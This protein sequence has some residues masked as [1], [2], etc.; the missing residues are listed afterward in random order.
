[1]SGPHGTSETN[2]MERARLAASDELVQFLRRPDAYP[3]S[4]PHVECVETHISWVFL[5]DRHAYKLKKPVKHD[6]VDFS[7][8]ELRRAACQRE[9]QLNRR[10]A[11]AVYLGVVPVTRDRRG[12][13]HLGG[14]NGGPSGGPGVGLGTP[15]DWLVHMRRLPADKSL[16]ALLRAG[17]LDAADVEHLAERLVR[18]YR[19]LPPLPVKTEAY[20]QAIQ[21]HVS[22]NFR[23][24][25]RAE[26]QLPKGTVWRPHAAQ[27]RLL[28]LYP[29]LWDARV[30]DGRVIEGHGD[31]RPEHVYFV[32]QPVLIDA[33]EFNAELRQIDVLDELGFLAMECAALDAPW[34]GRQ[35]LDRYMTATGD[36]PAEILLRFYEAYRACVRAKVHALRAAQEKPLDAQSD[37]DRAAKYLSW[38]N[39]SLAE[40]STPLL[41]VVHGLSGTGKSEL[42]TRWADA[43]GC[44]LLQTDSLRRE[45]D[46][47][48]SSTE[49][50]EYGQGVYS[51]VRRAAVYE[52]L[53]ERAEQ[54]LN[55]GV[56]VVLDGA[57]LSRESRVRARR[58]AA[59]AGAEF[60]RVHCR[61][62][63]R[64][65]MER[66]AERRANPLAIS[67]IPPQLLERQALDEQAD[68][69][70]DPP[71][72]SLDTT[73][74]LAELLEAVYAQL[75]A[76]HPVRT[77]AD[78]LA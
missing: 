71:H 9:V 11:P 49:A 51:D 24:L 65:A 14:P 4:T 16:D 44:E 54:R 3:E 76:R 30:C 69:T 52:T 15:I 60:L 78:A 57:F 27:L 7:D 20:R 50:P 33:I 45:L 6:F 47:A 29:A 67:E 64:V 39:A 42:A 61:C 70:L 74:P 62:P 41:L 18:F 23:E 28:K 12:R 22:N 13:L 66:V 34:V 58:I 5:T 2:V 37:R 10:L 75:R 8:V 25:L 48:P 63:L 40:W 32:P 59:S 55:A 19:E 43:L 17:R 38:A 68:D 36:A 26:H 1:M 56:S 72:C 53:F 73:A 46:A 35:V 77:E 31:L 21:T